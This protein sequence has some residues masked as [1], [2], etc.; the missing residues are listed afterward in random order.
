MIKVVIM[1][2]RA[3][4]LSSRKACAAIVSCAV[5]VSALL[6]SCFGAS[7]MNVDYM[8]PD[9][10]AKNPDV[11][12][13]SVDYTNEVNGATLNGDLYYLT[14]GEL[15]LYTYLK[16]AETNLSPEADNVY[17]VYTVHAPDDDY[18]ICIGREGLTE[19]SSQQARKL[20][21]TEANFV[22]CGNYISAIQY[23]GAAESIK[24]DITLN[25]NGMNYRI[26]ENIIGRQLK[27]KLTTSAKETATKKH[28]EKKHK[29]PGKKQKT[30]AA[31]RETTTKFH[32]SYTITTTRKFKSAVTETETRTTDAVTQPQPEVS[33]VYEGSSANAVQSKPVMGRWAKLLLLIAALLA[34]AGCGVLVTTAALKDK[35]EEPKEEN[36]EKE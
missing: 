17:I 34:A 2:D 11:K 18:E 14:D 3:K 8:N 21:K 5:L 15:C 6:F 13:M 20:F 27:M 25:I 10:W 36:N 33:T 9:K 26:T 35:K 24:T 32:P 7:A 28:K 23:K 19:E 16:I 30:K 31:K 22:S 12:R 29:K 4:N 1:K